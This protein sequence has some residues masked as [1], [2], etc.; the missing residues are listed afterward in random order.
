VR[1]K[2]I[3][4]EVGIIG[5]GVAGLAAAAE[6]TRAGA[7]VCILEAANRIGG[8]ILT[9]RDPLSPIPIE[10]GAEF[11]HGRPPE[12][13]ELI[14]SSTLT[15]CEHTTRALHFSK[16]KLSKDSK[17]GDS[18][19]KVLE[20]M[21]KSRRKSDETFEDYLSHSRHSPRA[22]AWAR[23]QIEGF[24]AAS[25]DAIS[26]GSLLREADAADEIEGDRVFRILNG[27]DSVPNTLLER[28]P[29]HRSVVRLD[30]PVQGVEWSPG[31]VHVEFQSRARTRRILRCDKL[32]VTVSLGVL[33]S[34]AIEFTPEPTH[35]MKAARRLK[36][37]QVYRVTLRFPN[38]FWEDREELKA[39]GFVVSQDKHFF[40]WWT[41]HPMQSPLLTAW[42]A[43]TAVDR[44]Q[45]SKKGDV[46]SEAC[47]SLGRILKRKIPSPEAAYFHDWRSDPHFLGAYSYVPVT[48]HGAREALA[49]PV[50]GTLYFAGEAADI[51]GRGSTVHGAIA[52][53]R[54]AASFVIGKASGV[55]GKPC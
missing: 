5:A 10:L 54:R 27:Y 23:L 7:D 34:G 20:A 41:S 29:N 16:G 45:N 35:A 14:Q 6:L 49:D 33:Q 40:T 17:I 9:I 28:I 55:L 2:G 52:S 1:V 12:I 43:G 53:G 37:G 15:A 13:W 30:S 22:K 51:H 24:N 25:S 26:I 11:V 47:A 32:I 4:C 36:F 38:A 48:G 46:A 8:R 50:A 42:M 44:F 39:A 19:D 21:A 3:E 31:R 18:A